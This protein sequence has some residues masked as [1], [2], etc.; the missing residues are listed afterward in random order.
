[1]KAC[2]IIQLLSVI[3]LLHT[4]TLV[5]H[6]GEQHT[7]AAV[8]LT[9]AEE[10]LPLPN[11]PV[12]DRFGVKKGF[13]DSI[14]SSG[15]VILS[16]TYTSC[17]TVCDV[18]N[19][20]LKVVDAKLAET[21]DRDVTIITVGIDAVRDTPQAMQSL[22]EMLHSSADWLWLTGGPRG[23]RPLLEALRFPAGALESHDPMFLI[24]RPCNGRF[25]R[26]V[27]LANPSALLELLDEQSPCES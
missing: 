20:I 10:R 4:K 5:A 15:P 6:E 1:M 16:F 19:A 2:L 12:V 13:R 18:S 14:P 8:K 26:V 22:A 9:P 17:D 21:P 25:T 23:T 3:A 27:G 24:G 11:L 7:D